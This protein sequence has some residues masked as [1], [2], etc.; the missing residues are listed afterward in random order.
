MSKPRTGTIY[1]EPHTHFYRRGV[2]YVSGTRYVGEIQ[3]HNKRY[4]KRSANYDTDAL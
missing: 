2:G 1:V 3:I 4:R